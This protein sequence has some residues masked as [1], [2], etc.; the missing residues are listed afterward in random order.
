MTFLEP[1][2]MV[3]GEDGTRRSRRKTRYSRGAVFPL[4]DDNPTLGTSFATLLLIAG[5][6]LAWALIQGLGGEPALSRS[7]CELGAVPGELLGTVAPGTSVPLARGLA[8]VVT[9]QANWLTPFSS[10]FLH[11]GWLH[12]V[13]NMWF[14]WVFGDNVEDAMGSVRFLVFY[15]LCGLAAVASQALV[16]PDSAIPMVGASGAIGGVMGAYAFLYPR[17]PVHMLIWILFYVDRIIVPAWLMLGYWFLLQLLSGLP[18]LSQETGGVAFF[19]HIGGFLAGLALIVP[20]RSDA[21]LARHRELMAGR[22]EPRGR[23]FV[24]R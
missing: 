15:L 7:I 6:L 1:D 22:F 23:D 19:A 10:M 16:N 8:C 13:G 20:F 11:G 2:A 12:L 17:A 24:G 5:N 18:S 9:D 14:L 21:R 3:G 4:R